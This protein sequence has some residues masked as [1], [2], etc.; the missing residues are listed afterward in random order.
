M[1]LV[2]VRSGLVD[3]AR[4]HLSRTLTALSGSALCLIIGLACLRYSFAEPLARLSYD[5]PFLWR[6]PL[7]THDVVLVYHDDDS[8]KQLHQPLDDIWNRALHMQLLA[9]LTNDHARL[10]F[11]DVVFDQSGPDA[12]AD[13]SFAQAMQDNG[14]VVLGGALEIVQPMSGVNQERVLPPIKLL[15]KA[16]AGWG[17]LAFK[18][19]D[20]DYG[21]R[22]LY[23]GTDNIPTAT[24]KAA[25][26]LGA[27]STRSEREV[28][29]PRW[30]NYYGPPTTLAAVNFAQALAPDGVS[31]DY[32]KDR[33][34]LIGGRSNVASGIQQKRD[35]F[36]TPFSRANHRFSTGLEIHATILLN[37]LRDE[38]L[39]RESR[40]AETF[41]ILAIGLLAG[42]LSIF[43]PW[44]AVVIALAACV[45]ITALATWFVW[46]ERVWFNWFVASGIQMP[47]GLIWAVGAQYV[48][49]SRRRKQ[50]RNAFSF[51]LSSHM[52]DKIADSNFDLKPGGKM[53]EATI[54]FTDL[55]NFTTMA[56]GL[57]PEE[58]SRTLIAYF[59]QTTECIL[60]YHGTI[61]DY[62]G[63]AVMA[64]WGAPLEDLEHTVHAVE[65]ACDLR[66]LTDLDVQGH[67][68]RTR[69]GVNTGQVLA[70]NLGSSHRFDYTMIGDT[71]NFASRLEGLNK[72]LG[73][74]VLISD[75]VR[76]KIDNRYVTRHL[77]EFRLAGKKNSVV[78]HE[79]LC[80]EKDGP[81]DH[82]WIEVFEKAVEAFREAEL[83]EARIL[84]ERTMTAR[85]GFDGP[86]DFYLR[87]IVEA[88][89][90]GGPE[91]W[92]GVISFAEK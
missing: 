42:G 28:D 83:E 88:Q 72:Y 59:E 5:L 29:P 21:V 31:S 34:V 16:A 91:E 47:L 26:L 78:I 4:K 92:T 70:G 24:W 64:G 41:F 80:R 27:R 8:A 63:D 84:M 71:T 43:R 36:A 89:K 18:P 35:E 57:T 17:L 11:Y 6:A 44:I 13:Q 79:L 32:F 30:I 3:L 20:A 19:V 69:V 9:R 54:M 22:Q 66:G 76:R 58:V 65:A 55:Q 45:E 10:A 86:A 15:R 39:H 48:R 56:E 87:K 25:E 77:G 67:K 2:L 50:L 49:E 46:H 85:G 53:V 51:Y 73:T 60:R 23:V 75:A 90:N 74:Q 81:N 82:G 33:I 12:A 61:I 38:W 14:H 62:F 1:N 68:L 7:D 52:A 37:L 40:G